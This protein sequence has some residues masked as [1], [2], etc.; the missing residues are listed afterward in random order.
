MLVPVQYQRL[1]AP[2]RV[3]RFRPVVFRLKFCTSAPF[4]AA[5][6][7][8]D[9]LAALARRLVEFYGMTEGGGTCILEAHNPDKLHTVGR[10]AEGHDIRLIDEAGARSAARRGRRGGGPLRRHDDRLPRPARATREAEW[11]DARASASSAPATSAASTRTASSPCSTASKDMII[12]GGF[13]IYPSDLEAVLRQHPAV[14]EAAVVG[15][16]STEWGETPVA[17]VVARRDPAAPRPCADW[18]ERAA[19]QDPAPERTASG[20]RTAAQRHRQGAQARVARP[21]T[22][23]PAPAATM[24][25][26][27]ARHDVSVDHLQCSARGHGLHAGDCSHRQTCAVACIQPLLVACVVAG[28]CNH[29]GSGLA[30]SV[31]QVGTH[32]LAIVQ[33]SRGTGQ[34]PFLG[35][36][37]TAGSEDQRLPLAARLQALAPNGQWSKEDVLPRD[38]THGNALGGQAADAAFDAG[39]ACRAGQAMPGRMRR[40]ELLSLG[41]GATSDQAGHQR[42]GATARNFHADLHGAM[43]YS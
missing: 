17:F 24:L 3:R 23:L 35:R 5:E 38:V 30:C 15:V 39:A 1:M 11:F 10:P 4:N 25:P 20:E 43:A 2:A 21:A 36:P 22:M 34:L 9:V 13:N 6:L 19:R 16:P 14:A 8:A 29:G 18:A 40:R 12:S 7:K 42:Q 41:L 27:T 28:P 31:G 26:R 33:D 32:A 37:R